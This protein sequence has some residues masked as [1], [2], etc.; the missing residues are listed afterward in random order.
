[1][2]I[3]YVCMN[4]YNCCVNTIAFM[5]Y[6]LF[7][8]AY[9]YSIIGYTYKK[10]IHMNMYIFMRQILNPI[11]LVKPFRAIDDAMNFTKSQF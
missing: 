7:K 9:M 5:I 11:H 10:N 4:I 1:M 8:H 2:F 3:D 6:F